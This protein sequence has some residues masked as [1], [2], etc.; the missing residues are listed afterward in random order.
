MTTTD[1]AP[2]PPPPPPQRP[3]RWPRVL[4]ALACLWVALARVPIILNAETHLDSDLAVDGL[5]LLDAVR[6]HWRWHYP[7]TPHMGSLPVLLSLAP[8]DG[9]GRQCA[10]SPV[11]AW[12][13]MSSWCWPRFSWRGGRFGPIVAAGAL[14][15]LAFASTGSIWLSGRIT[16]GHL[17]T[18]AWHGAAFWGLC[19]CVRTRPG[20]QGLRSRDLVRPGTLP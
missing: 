2:P 1:S 8:G 6:G 3:A 14:V 16:G 17:L 10:R 5:T 9:L 12:S 4:R 11:A 15:P 7:G 18:L 19:G 13:R 20:R